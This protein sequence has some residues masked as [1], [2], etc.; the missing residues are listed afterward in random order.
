MPTVSLSDGS[1]SFD[2]LGPLTTTFTQPAR[3]TQTPIHGFI[4][5]VLDYP[6]WQY[7]VECN[8]TVDA[9]CYPPSTNSFTGTWN[10]REWLG[11]G[12][13]YSPG[14]LCPSGW[15]TVGA[16]TRDEHHSLTFSGAAHPSKQPENSWIYLYRPQTA[17]AS[18]LEPGQTMA[19]CCPSYS[20]QCNSS[21][22]PDAQGGCYST[23]SERPAS[24]C[25]VYQE[26]DIDYSSVLST[27]T[28]ATTTETS[29][30]ATF[31]TTRAITTETDYLTGTGFLDE[32]TPVSWVDM[33]MIVHHQSDLSEATDLLIL[34]STSIR[35][36]TLEVNHCP[37]HISI[38][39][40]KSTT[41][42]FMSIKPEHIQNIALRTK[43]HEYRGYLLPSSIQ[44][45]WFYTSSPTQSIEYVAHISHGKRPGELPDDG[46]IGNTEFN[47][48]LKTSGYAY[49]ILILWKLRDPLTLKEAIRDGHLKG[50][51]QKYC[52]VPLT[53]L[54]EYPLEKLI[55]LFSTID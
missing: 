6:L 20:L 16:A 43:N 35:A 4:T 42:I 10:P 23:L 25:V 5:T 30:S 39:M 36:K 54:E 34:T 26:A 18:A 53:F 3:C 47:T 50:P 46:G 22:T 19:M 12:D 48:G 11:Y 55:L 13:Y 33:I 32:L 41:D 44:R 7:G 38:T 29:W 1:W 40:S 21:M 8:P 52:W 31:T 14:L 24:A 2:N 15:A 27:Y 17:L 28:D 9:S 45:I 37:Q 49:E 51:P